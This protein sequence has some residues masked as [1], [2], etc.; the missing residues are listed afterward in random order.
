MS[1]NYPEKNVAKA[2]QHLTALNALKNQPAWKH[3]VLPRLAE[4]EEGALLSLLEDE[5]SPAERE[6]R[7]RIWRA[8]QAVVKF[9]ETDERSARFIVNS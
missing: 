1:T 4:I 2:E 6:I 3:Y 5:I 7:H 8:I 9:P